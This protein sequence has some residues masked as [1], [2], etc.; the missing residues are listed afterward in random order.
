LND[1]Q[2]GQNEDATNNGPNKREYSHQLDDRDSNPRATKKTKKSK[3]KTK[4]KKTN[5]AAPR[6]KEGRRT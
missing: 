5:E 6:H 3:T 2:R 1:S 4:K